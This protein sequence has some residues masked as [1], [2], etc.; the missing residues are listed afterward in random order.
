MQ[1][2]FMFSEEPFQIGDRWYIEGKELQEQK[3]TIALHIPEAYVPMMQLAKREES[4]LRRGIRNE[5]RMISTTLIPTMVDPVLVAYS[6]LRDKA[7]CELHALGKRIENCEPWYAVMMSIL[8][9]KPLLC[10][11][12]I[13][14]QQERDR[15]DLRSYQT[16]ALQLALR[17][18][19]TNTPQGA[20][21]ESIIYR[22]LG[23]RNRIGGLLNGLCG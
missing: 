23:R 8:W 11:Q 22:E 5:L 13:L 15:L 12:E 20:E 18:L 4:S 9:K 21:T 10:D 2:K 16:H 6:F 17:L 3:I 14:T 19:D 1:K 7:L